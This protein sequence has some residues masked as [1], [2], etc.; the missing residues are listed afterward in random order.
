MQSKEVMLEAQQFLQRKLS[1]RLLLLKS[2]SWY[3][4]HTHI[5]W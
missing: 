1:W 2:Y 3:N 4:T 5:Q